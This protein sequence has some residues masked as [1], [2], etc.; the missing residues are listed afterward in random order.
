METECNTS[1]IYYLT[2]TGWSTTAQLQQFTN[3]Q[4]KQTE[5]SD[6]AR[7][8]NEKETQNWCKQWN[9]M[10]VYQTQSVV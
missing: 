1:Y 6:L 2:T 7:K 5:L 9:V 4:H 10:M 3:T 8:G